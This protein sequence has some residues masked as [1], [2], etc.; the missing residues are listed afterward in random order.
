MSV[1]MNYG[2]MDVWMYVCMDVWTYG[3][4][5]G[6]MDICDTHKGIELTLALELRRGEVGGNANDYPLA[7]WG[8]TTLSALHCHPGQQNEIALRRLTSSQHPCESTLLLVF[9]LLFSPDGNDEANVTIG[10]S[11]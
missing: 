7:C 3:C 1:C 5:C 6:C 10:R 8:G 4:M 2:C 9:L 11:R